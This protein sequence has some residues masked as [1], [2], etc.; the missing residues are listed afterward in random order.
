MEKMEVDQRKDY[1]E[2]GD[3]DD[4]PHSCLTGVPAGRTKTRRGLLAYQ[5]L[6][7]KVSTTNCRVP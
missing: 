2:S 3:D 6:D 1:P 4:V 5:H 7:E